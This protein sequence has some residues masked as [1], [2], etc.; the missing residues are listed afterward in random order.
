MTA[1]VR[2]VLVGAGAQVPG[3]AL[4]WKALYPRGLRCEKEVL[5]PQLAG[6]AHLHRRH[7]RPQAKAAVEAVGPG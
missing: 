4:R 2:G 1:A 3:L 7:L 6:G 5:L